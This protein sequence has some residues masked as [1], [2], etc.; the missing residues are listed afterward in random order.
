MRADCCEL[1]DAPIAKGMLE[2]RDRAELAEHPSVPTESAQGGHDAPRSQLRGRPRRTVADV[3]RPVLERPRA[4]ETPEL[5]ELVVTAA[6]ERRPQ[7][8]HQRDAIAGRA[9]RTAEGEE[10]ADLLAAVDELDALNAVA[11]AGPVERLL[12]ETETR[13]AR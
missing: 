9:D 1:E 12:E 6:K 10:L 4:A 8:R 13:T 5:V 7:H 2:R 11:D 3:G